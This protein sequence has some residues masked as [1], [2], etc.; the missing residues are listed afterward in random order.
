MNDCGSAA[1]ALADPA[2]ARLS[3]DR[4][5]RHLAE[6]DT[7][8]VTLTAPAPAASTVGLRRRHH[9]HHPQLLPAHARRARHRGRTRPRHRAGRGR[10]RPHDGGDRRPVPAGL[11]SVESAPFTPAEATAAARAAIFDP[12]AV[13]A[14][15]DARGTPAGHR[16]AFAEAVR[17]EVERRKRAA[18]LRDFDDLPMLL[19]RVLSD[20]EHG[21]AAC[22]RVR[23]RYGVVLV[24]EFQDTDPLQW[25]IL[26]RA[27]HGSGTL[28]LVGDP[29]Q[30]IYAFRGAEVLSY[31][32]AV[33]SADRHQELTTNWRSDQDSSTALEYLL[34]RRRARASRDRGAP[35]R[36][37]ETEVASDGCRAA[38]AAVSAEDRR[39]ADQ[40]VG[41][42][43]GRAAP[44]ADR[45][46]PRRRH[47]RSP[48]RRR[49]TRRRGRAPDSSNPATSPSWCAP[50][51]RSRWSTTPS[52]GRVCRPCSP[53][54]PV[55]SPLRLR[56]TGSG[57][58][59]P[60]SSRTGPTGC[61]WPR[62]P[63]CSD[64]PAE[65][66]DARGDDIVAEVGGQLRELGAVFA[67]SGFAALF[68]RL[69]AVAALEARLLGSQRVS[70][71]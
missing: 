50:T 57:C 10:R 36:R 47:R 25:D 66:L 52:T 21:A 35:R 42:P 49:D 8:E 45:G 56:S 28:V 1:A 55:S 68:E 60:S 54:G 19:H 53:V 39:R 58:C 24:D 65:E 46:R 61:G 16:V 4:L 6:A 70:G 17:A 31:L 33:R 43:R 62:S 26:R 69:S 63:R 44:E 37:C 14:P 32:D 9:R 38:A 30:A 29:K 59:R 51:R 34:R 18:G 48:R 2:A 11:Q 13:L 64:T 22:R 41:I 15:E 27:F 23:E 40:Q 67:Q 7:D 3:A 71:H 5:I 20:P 12:Q